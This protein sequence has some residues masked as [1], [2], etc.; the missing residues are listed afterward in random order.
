MSAPTMGNCMRGELDKLPPHREPSRGSTTR[1]PKDLDELQRK[2][3]SDEGIGE[4][5]ICD[6]LHDIPG[7]TSNATRDAG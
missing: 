2:L 7:F 6:F 3:T 5:I 1:S 4:R